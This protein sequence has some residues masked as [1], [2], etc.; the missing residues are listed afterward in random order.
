MPAQQRPELVIP[1]RRFGLLA[2]TLLVAGGGCGPEVP[3][4]ALL[5]PLHLIENFEPHPVRHHPTRLAE[6]QL[7]TF[8]IRRPSADLAEVV[9]IDFTASAVVPKR[10]LD[11]LTKVFEERKG[12]IADEI[13]RIVKAASFEELNQ[14]EMV[15]LKS[16][17]KPAVAKL[18]KTEEVRDIVFSDYSVNVD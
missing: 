12:R 11:N 7:G 9:S 4:S 8:S 6:I 10:F 15:Y 18:L 5:D 13:N 1:G 16:E 17:L 14:V 3:D 2:L